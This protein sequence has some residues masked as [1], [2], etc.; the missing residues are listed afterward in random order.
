MG[1]ARRTGR[2]RAAYRHG[3]IDDL[4]KPE[5]KTARYGEL[6]K[7]VHQAHW[8]AA[9]LLVKNEFDRIYSGAGGSGMN[10]FTSEDMTAYFVT[11]PAK[12]A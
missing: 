9:R 10:A 8:R 11:V 5:N 3:E 1:C 6:D 4:L 7:R 2:C 12:Q